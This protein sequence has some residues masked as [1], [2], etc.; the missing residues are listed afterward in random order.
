MKARLLGGIA[1]LLLAI[2]GTVMLVN[3][4]GGADRRALEGTKSTDVVV[5]QKAIAAGTPVS[6]FGDAVKVKQIPA[7]MMSSGAIA[8]LQDVMS[9]VASTPMLPGDQVTDTRLAS[10]QAYAGTGVVT[11]P[12]TMQQLSFT[13]TADRVVGGQLKPGE[14]AALF[15]SY[16]QGVDPGSQSSPA[17]ELTLRKVLVVSMQA[18]GQA[19]SG[20][21]SAS[22]ASSPPSPETA[23]QNI[24]A[25]DWVVTVALAPADAQKLV[26][27]AEFGHIW[28]AREVSGP[29][30]ASPAPL[31]KGGVFK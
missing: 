19:G 8:S 4:V 11:V 15:L 29:V 26:F 6:A 25:A 18:S 3:Y 14:T 22:T 21:S 31:F 27:A 23:P 12:D 13:V 10:E 2:I 7:N 30:G 28:V 1:A 16:N 9:K 20:S 24:T 17:T 5:V